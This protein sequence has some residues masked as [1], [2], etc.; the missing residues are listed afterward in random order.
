MVS[1]AKGV[2]C[3]FVF[4]KSSPVSITFRKN[5]MMFE[6]N[7]D[8]LVID[9]ATQKLAIQKVNLAYSLI[10][11]RPVPTYESTEYFI[12]AINAYYALH[13]LGRCFVW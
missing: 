3:V 7:R 11:C 9:L 5:N 2:S 10:I 4:L 13:V 8:I 1:Q 6:S 12:V